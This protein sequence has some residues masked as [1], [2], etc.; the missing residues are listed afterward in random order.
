MGLLGRMVSNF[1][2]NC[3][4]LFQSGC[5]IML[6]SWPRRKSQSFQIL[7][8]IWYCWEY[9]L[10]VRL[11][12]SFP[13]EQIFQVYLYLDLKNC[14]CSGTV[15]DYQPALSFRYTLLPLPPFLLLP[16]HQNIPFPSIA[17]YYTRLKLIQAF[18]RCWK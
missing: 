9:F 17:W 14:V 8:S 4:A 12:F 13:F 7:V 10:S 18:P 5:T 11:L 16:F 3:L 1:V 2:R 6:L 15:K